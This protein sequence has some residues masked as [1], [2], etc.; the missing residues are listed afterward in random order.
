MIL[1]PLS[2]F[3]FI[4]SVDARKIIFGFASFVY[5]FNYFLAKGYDSYY[6]SI[7]VF[8]F[9]FG[10]FVKN[11]ERLRLKNYIGLSIGLLILYLSHVFSYALS[12]FIIPVYVLLHDQN[13]RKLSKVM[14]AFIPSFILFGHYAFFVLGKSESL[15]E[16][17]QYWFRYDPFYTSVLYSYLKTFIGM[18]TYSFSEWAILI[19]YIPVGFVI[20]LIAQ[21]VVNW[22]HEAPRAGLS[23]TTIKTI[24]RKDTMLFLLVILTFLFFVFPSEI[25]GWPKFNKR[26]LPFIFIFMLVSP[27]MFSKKILQK[28]YI[29]LASVSCILMIVI[30]TFQVIKINDV[31]DDYTSGIPFIEKNKTLLPVHIETYRVGKISPVH[32]AF[33][34]YNIDKGGATNMSVAH[35]TGRVYIN[36]KHSAKS[37]FPDLVH[38]LLFSAAIKYHADLDNGVIPEGLKKQFQDNG[39]SL[40]NSIELR[41]ENKGS[42]WIIMDKNIQK[43]YDIEIAKNMLNVY[44]YPF[45]NKDIIAQIGKV[46]DYVLFW[47]ENKWVFELFEN[48]GFQLLHQQG[49]LRLYSNISK[50]AKAS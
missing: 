2:V 45:E 1:L 16:S 32:W 49:A 37:Q 22:Y 7:P 15:L 8:F 35:Y 18:A 9:C 33:N 5:V 10:Y 23:K 40:T 4:K 28:L 41:I 26:L 31:L 13:Y 27:A 48:S 21:K 42:H 24:V 19:F 12:I 39:F 44:D 50:L 47:G 14:T 11:Y 46:Y 34:Y 6:F 20:Y 30:M 43:T 25:M 38:G 29:G 17:N 36:Y 3:Y